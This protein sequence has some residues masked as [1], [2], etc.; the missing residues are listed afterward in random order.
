MN[1]VVLCV[2]EKNLPKTWN[3]IISKYEAELGMRIQCSIETVPLGTAGPLRLA[4]ALITN[5]GA[6]TEPFFVLNGDVLCSFPLKDMIHSHLKHKGVGTIMTTRNSQ[7]GRYGVVVGD[8]KTG[9]I[10]HFVNRPEWVQLPSA[11]PPA[12]RAATTQ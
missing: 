11:A 7:P 9:K 4:Q 5:D 12:A 1:D 10:E 6:S 8:E 2:N 3:E